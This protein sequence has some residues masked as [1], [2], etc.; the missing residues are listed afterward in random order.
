MSALRNLYNCAS[1]SACAPNTISLTSGSC[2]GVRIS[3]KCRCVGGLRIN[4]CRHSP[5]VPSNSVYGVGYFDSASFCPFTD[6]HFRRD[7]TAVKLTLTSLICISQLPT[8]DCAA[9]GTW[10]LLAPT[11]TCAFR[12]TI[13]SKSW[14]ALESGI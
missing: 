9:C 6:G 13:V 7:A 14:H 1:S 3:Y 10:E 2:G 12:A 11:L 5:N 8:A 4:S